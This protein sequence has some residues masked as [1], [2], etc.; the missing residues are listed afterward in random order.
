MATNYGAIQDKNR[1]KKGILV[2]AELNDSFALR[3]MTIITSTTM[4]TGVGDSVGVTGGTCINLGQINESTVAM[5]T[6]KTEFKNEAGQAVK[7]DFEYA[8]TTKGTLMERDKAKIDLLSNYVKGRY[9]LEI[10]YLGI[11]DG[12]H[13]ELFKIVEITPQH[14]ITLP[15]G[16]TSMKYES[17][18]VFPDV[19]V[20]FTKTSLA[21]I[22]TALSATIYGALATTIVTIPVKAGYY[23]YERTVS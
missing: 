13:Q 21:L 20:T 12:K 15:G 8:L 3:T 1:N 19:A 23:L 5:E 14:A 10:K 17:T 11:V 9:Y 18:G 7:T 2:L 16:A 4:V 6:S 22:A